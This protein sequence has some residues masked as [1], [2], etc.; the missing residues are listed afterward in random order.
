MSLKH[1]ISIAVHPGEV[2]QEELE[3][4]GVS[5][6]ALAE[7]LGVHQSKI[8]EICKGRRG[9][10]PE[11]SVQLSKAFGTS[12]SFWMNLQSQWE[13]SQVDEDEYSDIGEI[14]A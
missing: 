10:S 3:A 12:P 7:H 8:N 13:L 11:M 4:R 6:T 2:L 9:L 5:Q 14:A 1:D